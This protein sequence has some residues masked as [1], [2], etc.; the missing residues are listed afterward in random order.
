LL[1]QALEDL[2]GGIGIRVQHA[3]NLRLERIEFT[4]P[5]P[6]LP[7]PEALLGEPARAVAGLMASPS[8]AKTW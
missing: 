3:D 6:R 5:V 7:G 2:G 1:A 8:S 4:A